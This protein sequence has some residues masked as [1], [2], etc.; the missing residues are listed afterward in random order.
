MDTISEPLRTSLPE[1]LTA[2]EVATVLRVDPR[3]IYRLMEEGEIPSVRIGQRCIRVDT[4]DL[5][6]YLGQRREV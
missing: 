4:V 5:I 2:T 6:N 3:T 1:F